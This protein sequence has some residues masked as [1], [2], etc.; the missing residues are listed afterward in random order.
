MYMMG[1]VHTDGRFHTGIRDES[2]VSQLIFSIRFHRKKQ[3]LVV[4]IREPVW[5]W[6]S[7]R[8]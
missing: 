2:G 4:F 7:L 5:E 1:S 3:M 8:A 6:R